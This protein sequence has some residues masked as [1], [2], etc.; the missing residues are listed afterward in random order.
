MIKAGSSNPLQDNYLDAYV[1]V[2]KDIDPFT[3][4][5]VFNCGM[6][7]VRSEV[8]LERKASANEKQATFGMCAALLVRRKQFVRIGLE[9]PFSAANDSSGLATVCYVVKWL[10]TVAHKCPNSRQPLLKPLTISN[11][12]HCSKHLIRVS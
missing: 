8:Y 5:L 10:F 4:S 3:T 7:V 2:L 6:G 9:D 12:L 11:K 1:S